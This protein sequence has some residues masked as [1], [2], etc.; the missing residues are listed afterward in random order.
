MLP[1]TW[2][3]PADTS[4]GLAQLIRDHAIVVSAD[5]WMGALLPDLAKGNLR[6]AKKVLHRVHHCGVNTAILQMVHHRAGFLILR[7]SRNQLVQEPLVLFPVCPRAE[8]RI[9][10]P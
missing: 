1:E 4:R 5:F 10:K 8:P 6:I 2:G 9:G 3:R 7:P